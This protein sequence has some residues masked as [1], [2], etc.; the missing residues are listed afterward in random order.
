MLLND[1]II[2][3]RFREG[4]DHEVMMEPGTPYQVTIQLPPTSNLFAA[5]HRIRIDVSSSNFPRLE[6]N[7]NTGE[8]IGRHTH[9]VGRRADGVLRRGASVAGGA[10]GDPGMTEVDAGR[11]RDLTLELVEVA[12]PTGD[13]AEVARLYA[14]RLEQIGM[15]VEV[16]D[17][18]LPEDAD[19][20]RPPAGRPARADGRAQRAPRRR[21]D[22]ARPA[23]RSRAT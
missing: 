8:P 6:R 3:T 10:A 21:P 13:T 20:D 9:M 18:R 23:P 14:E 7:P 11:L 12:S 15:D 4:F 22:P 19:R 1:S 16:L 5:G 17:E 2:R